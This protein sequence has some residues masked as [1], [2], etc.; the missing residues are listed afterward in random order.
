MKFEASYFSTKK[1]I[2]YS[3]QYLRDEMVFF[4]NSSELPGDRSHQRP[5]IA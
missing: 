3:V 5:T 1:S 4:V 2:V